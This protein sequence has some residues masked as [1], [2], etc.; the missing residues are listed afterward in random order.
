[1]VGIATSTLDKLE[2]AKVPV[3]CNWFKSDLT[4]VVEYEL[5]VFADS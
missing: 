1:M 3:P 5:G 2:L 4:V